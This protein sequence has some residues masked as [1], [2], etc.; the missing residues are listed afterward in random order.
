MLTVCTL[1]WQPNAAS[2]DFSRMYDESWV[3]RLHRGFA[4]NLTVPFRLVLFTDRERSFVEPVE[5]VVQ[6]D[7]GQGGY[8][9]CIRPYALNS[10]MILVGL[11]TIV[12]G[13]CDELAL[14]CFEKTVLCLPR[15]PY[16]PHQAING[17]GLVPA[18]HGRIASEHHGENDMVHVRRYPHRLIDDEF[19]GMVRSYKGHAEKHGLGDTR[20]VYFH[21]LKKPHELGHVDWIK[22]HWR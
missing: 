1:L 11:D 2:R 3:E 17:V 18:G 15:D 19:P 8:G 20:I 10:P 12:T 21:G 14:W 6:P 16:R 22:E 4:R 9:D 13:N 5:Q 7:L